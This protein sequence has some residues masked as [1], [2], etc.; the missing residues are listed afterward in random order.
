MY[1]QPHSQFPLTSKTFFPPCKFHKKNGKSFFPPQRKC[2]I[3]E[4]QGK[5]GKR[6][7]WLS[8]TVKTIKFCRWKGNKRRKMEKKILRVYIKKK[9]KFFFLFFL[10]VLSSRNADFFTFAKG[11][12]KKSCGRYTKSLGDR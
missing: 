7:T 5:N 6:T 9:K 2:T 11:R 3:E 1:V 8:S 4:F 10:C 12:K